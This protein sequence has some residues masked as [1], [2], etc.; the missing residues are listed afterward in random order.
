MGQIE[1]VSNAERDGIIIL[2]PWSERML[3][4]KMK[5]SFL[6]KR[7]KYMET[8]GRKSRSTFLAGPT[9]QLKIIFTLSFEH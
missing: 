1:M 8:N 7:T 6:Q 2:I 5:N 9:I 4:T 3:G